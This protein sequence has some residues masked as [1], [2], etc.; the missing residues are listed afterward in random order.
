MPGMYGGGFGGPGSFGNYM[1]QYGS[2]FT[3]AG[4]YGYYPGATGFGA[5]PPPG[6]AGGATQRR[7][8]STV[9]GGAAGADQTGAYAGPGGQ[10]AIPRIPHII[11]NPIDNTLFIQGTPQEYQQILKLL[12]EVDIPP[13][14]VLIDAKVYEVSLTG[15][16]A[17]GVSA[18]FQSR[19]NADR[20]ILAKTAGG[21]SQLSAGWLVSTSKEL[22]GFLSLAENNT[23][24]RVMSA[25]S[26][27]AT[28]SIAATINVG[29]EVPTLTASVASPIQSGGNSLFANSIQS[30]QTGVS[31][32]ITA[33][34]NPSGIVTLVINQEVSAPQ[35]PQAGQI[36]SPS[37]SRR[38][39]NTQVTVQDGDTIAI[40]G[41]INET[42]AQ[43][44]AGIPVLHRLPVVGHAF[45]SKSYSKE[46]TELII[47]MTPR[48]IYDTNQ[49]TDASDELKGRLKR[50]QKYYRE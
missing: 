26:V 1:P 18:A 20:S 16:F 4:Q 17:S 15:A 23:N 43:S 27:I 42:N 31:L 22:L 5:P 32:S 39:V 21:I 6:A 38:S 11:P 28:D 29:V 34:I 45:G 36:Q 14:Q 25:P 47:F 2:P 50:L 41:I 10:A 40:G 33:R 37:F 24:A 3:G 19:S 12:R 35:A 13:R 30:R 44:T 48:V 49:M 9:G 7:A 8:T 46:R